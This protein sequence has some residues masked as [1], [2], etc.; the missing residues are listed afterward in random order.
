[1]KFSVP[2]SD[3]LYITQSYF[4]QMKQ[5]IKAL[6]QICGGDD[7]MTHNFEERNV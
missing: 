5:C 2:F 3:I 4:I 6:V 7:L 1:M